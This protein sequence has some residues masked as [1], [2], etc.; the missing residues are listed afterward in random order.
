MGGSALSSGSLA[1][2]PSL[3][4]VRARCRQ[5]V[6]LPRSFSNADSKGALHPFHLF[7]FPV[8]M[9]GIPPKG[10][11][12]PAIVAKREEGALIAAL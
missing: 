2:V 5:D 1:F 12:I 9:V 3:S 10:L 11:S 6:H 8:P 4:L 7:P